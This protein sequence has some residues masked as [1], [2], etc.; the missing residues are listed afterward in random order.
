LQ[1]LR[2]AHTP[3]ADFRKTNLR[4]LREVCRPFTLLCKQL[5]LFGAELVASDGSKCR[6]VT[7]TERNF[8]QDKLTQLMAQIAERVAAS[9]KALDR[10]DE[11]DDR[12]TVGGTHAAALA[13]KIEAL[14][15]RKLRYEGFQAQ[16]LSSGQDHRSLTDPESRSMQRGKGRGTAVCYNVQTAVDAKPKLIV[17]CE[18]TNDPGDRAWLSPMALQAQEVLDS[19]CE[20]VADVGSYHGHEGKACLEAG[21]TPYVSR[22]ITSANEKLG[23]FSTNDFTYDRA[24]DPYQCPAGQ[25]LTFRFDPVELGRHIRYDATSA[26]KGCAITQ[27]CPRSKDGRRLTRWVD[28]HL[29]EEREQR[30][31]SR[32]E[33]MKRRKELAEHPCGTMQRWWDDGY[34]LMRGLEKVRTECRLTVLA[35]NLRRVLNLVEIPRLLATLGCVVPVRWAAG[36]A[37]S[38]TGGAE[39]EVGCRDVLRR[40]GRRT[41][42]RYCGAMGGGR[43][44]ATGRDCQQGF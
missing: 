17:A 3:I 11:H 18:V 19:P 26:C 38:I 34:L 39:E 35:S 24:T 25:V 2:P 13:A 33:V 6:A 4:P 8:P 44:P 32:P 30:V 7:T 15:P 23:L 31:R 42:G 41:T 10:S 1:K 37:V 12:G 22:P 43:L 40:R 9:L 27:P 36:W 21:L 29:L 16:M 5:D 20:A 28:E 14:K